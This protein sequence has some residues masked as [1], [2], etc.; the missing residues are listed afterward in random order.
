M[1]T[2]AIGTKDFVK[3][4]VLVEMNGINEQRHETL[5][6]RKRPK[7][8]CQLRICLITI[9]IAKS[10]GFPIVDR[11]PSLAASLCSGSFQPENVQI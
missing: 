6:V 2:I 9:K 11:L 10:S 3:I 1:K 7:V 5:T 4:S 8:L